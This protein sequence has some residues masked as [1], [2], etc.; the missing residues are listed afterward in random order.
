MLDRFV[1]AEGSPEVVQF[2]GGEPT[3]HPDSVRE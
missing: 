3:I 1:A 2:S